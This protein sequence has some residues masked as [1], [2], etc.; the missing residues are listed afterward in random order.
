MRVTD[1]FAASPHDTQTTTR[2]YV[3]ELSSPE[4]AYTVFILISN[5]KWKNNF[6]SNVDASGAALFLVLLT[7]LHLCS[8]F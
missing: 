8:L 5:I 2:I 6:L 1:L 4:F 7:Y 3:V